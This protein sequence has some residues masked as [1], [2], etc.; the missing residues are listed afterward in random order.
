MIKFSELWKIILK[1]INTEDKIKDQIV[2]NKT[3]AAVKYMLQ[4]YNIYF[5][6][7]L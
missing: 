4:N 6:A 3:R 2:L 7:A 5:T 1:L